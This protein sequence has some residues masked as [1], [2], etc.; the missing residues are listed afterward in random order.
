MISAPNTDIVDRILPSDPSR[1][2]GVV[3]QH[4]AAVYFVEPEHPE[5]QQWLELLERSRSEGIEIRFTYQIAGQRLES[6]VLTK[7]SP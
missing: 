5:A 2:V 4:H 1:G 7:V 6:V 3:F